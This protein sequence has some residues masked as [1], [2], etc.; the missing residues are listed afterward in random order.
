MS[1]EDAGGCASVSDKQT[2]V[3]NN[4]KRYLKPNKE[5]IVLMHDIKGYTAAGLET[6]IQYGLANNYTFKAIDDSTEPVHFR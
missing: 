2:C 4:F 3:I 5:N 6:M 1:I